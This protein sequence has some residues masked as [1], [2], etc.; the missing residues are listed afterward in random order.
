MIKKYILESIVFA[1]IGFVAYFVFSLENIESIYY[2]YLVYTLVFIILLFCNIFIKNKYIYFNT[3]FN[4]KI[5][6]KGK[7]WHIISIN[8]LGFYIIYIAFVSL[9]LILN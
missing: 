8:T 9:K 3:K 1:I 7:E 4:I 2:R 6:L 5:F